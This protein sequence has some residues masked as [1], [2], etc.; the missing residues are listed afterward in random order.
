MTSQTCFKMAELELRAVVCTRRLSNE[1]NINSEKHIQIE[2]PKMKDKHSK[3]TISSKKMDP[4]VFIG[5]KCHVFSSK[6]TSAAK[7]K[8]GHAQEDFEDEGVGS[9][10]S[11][12]GS[13]PGSEGDRK[14]RCCDRYDSS[15]SSDR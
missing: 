12:E 14:K 4:V 3:K 10:N 5:E 11:S 15:E 13:E 8:A 7:S 9:N 1:N 2:V 6:D